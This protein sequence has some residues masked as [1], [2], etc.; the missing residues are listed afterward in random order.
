MLIHHRF[1]V[2]SPP[3]AISR[4]T[5]AGWGGRPM[6]AHEVDAEHPTWPTNKPVFIG[7]QVPQGVHWDRGDLTDKN[8]TGHLPLDQ[9]PGSPGRQNRVGGGDSGRQHQGRDHRRGN[10]MR[11]RGENGHRC[12]ETGHLHHPLHDRP[13]PQRLTTRS[14]WAA[15]SNT[16]PSRSRPAPESAGACQSDGAQGTSPRSDTHRPPRK[17]PGRTGAMRFRSGVFGC[18]GQGFG[19]VARSRTGHP[20]TTPKPWS[21]PAREPTARTSSRLCRPCTQHLEWARWAQPGF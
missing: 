9:H 12:R 2:K 15:A 13:H 19:V 5:A 17:L 8:S 7:G 4:V 1:S 10:R 16:S 21:C 14:A 18:R 20:A 3:G 11:W 6:G